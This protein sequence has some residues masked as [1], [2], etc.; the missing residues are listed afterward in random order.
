M[1]YL[2]SEEVNEK[3]VIQIE[4]NSLF[5]SVSSKYEKSDVKLWQKIT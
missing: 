4:T 3:I 1:I 5:L 2:P